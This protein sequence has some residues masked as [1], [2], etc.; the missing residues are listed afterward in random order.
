MAKTLFSGRTTS[1]SHKFDNWKD[2][3]PDGKKCVRTVKLIDVQWSDC[4]VEI[5]DIV[6]DL[7]QA[8]ELNND[9]CIIKVDGLDDLDDKIEDPAACEL[10]KRY[11]KSQGVGKNEQCLIHWWW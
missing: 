9:N 4:P 5:E 1:H 7:W 11:L 8:Y 6:R 3:K 2:K 10:F